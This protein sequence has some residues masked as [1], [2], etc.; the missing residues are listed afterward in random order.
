[1]AQPITL[2]LPEARAIA[3]RA[4]GL[5]EDA[6]P[7]GLG[8]AGT[9]AALEHL[10]YVQVDTIH[11]L[12][13]AHHHVL[14]SRVPDYRPEFLHALQAEGT[15]F[16]YWNHAA[17]YLPTSGYRYSRRLMQKYRAHPHW[18][19]DTPE[20]RQ[21]M[22][23]M[24]ALIRAQGPLRLRDIE[25]TGKSASWSDEGMGKIERRALH[26]LWMRGELMIR[27]RH[28]MQKVFDLTA[29]VLPPDTDLRLPTAR[30]DAIFH[31]RRSLRALGLARAPELHYLRDCGHAG[32]IRAALLTLVKRRE[33]VPLEVAGHAAY[34][35]PAAL[36]NRAPIREEHVRILSP[37]DNLVIQR[38]RLQ[39]LFGFDFLTEIYVP[40][41]KR[42][43]GYFALPI[44]CGD[45]FIGRLDAKADRPTRHL[46]IHSLHFEPA[47]RD[48]AALTASLEKALIPFTHFQHCDRYTLPRS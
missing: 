21:S 2:P 43:Y 34:A 36:E 37:F 11:V 6:A 10:G 38:K 25:S 41:A 31:I 24:L 23:R 3:L 45:R 9:L 15:A 12:E 8:Q 16:E 18:A 46:R 13:R 4:Q 48:Q 7:F 30:E 47:I 5:A 42:K 22:R 44:L 28:G 29:R 17:S 27:E 39:W 19:Q 20:L 32:E 26:E 35:L 1:M 14:W 33:I 40:A